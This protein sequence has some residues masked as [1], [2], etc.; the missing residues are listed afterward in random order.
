MA[1]HPIVH[2]ELSAN[3]REAAGKFYSALFGWQ[4]QNHPEMNYSTFTAE[5]GPAGGFSQ[6]ADGMA[7]AGQTTVYVGTDD[8]D[9]TLAKAEQLGG[10][11]LMPKMEIPNTGWMG[12]FQDPTGNI[13]GLFTSK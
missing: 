12:L 6:V 13:V 10:K 5:G 7:T 11:V 9:G 4:V 8:I 2:V 1:G 3:D